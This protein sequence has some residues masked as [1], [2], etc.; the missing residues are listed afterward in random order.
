MAKRSILG[1]FPEGKHDHREC[2]SDALAAARD[3]CQR[4]GARL[5]ALRQ[6][7]LELVWGRHQPAGAYDILEEL[8]A[9][10]RG[11][12][13]ATV[14]RALDFLLE[15]GLVHRIESLNAFVG[16]GEPGQSHTGQ[17]LICR[18]C[19]TVA[20]MDDV[21]V[22]GVLARSAAKTGFRVDRQTVELSGL[23]PEC[24]ARAG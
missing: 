12:A 10:R 3:L 7:V 14:Y 23:C 9:D 22:A 11:A 17:F 16:C 24:H 15:H 13:P 19:R 2:V 6:R 21:D 20:E 4:R 18:R 8:K 1:P 5:T